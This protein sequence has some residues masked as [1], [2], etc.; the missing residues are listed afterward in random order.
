MIE[1]SANFKIITNNPKVK[2]KYSLVSVEPPGRGVEGVFL[3]VRNEIHLGANLISHPLSGSVKPNESPYKSIVL[4][5]ARG[6]LDTYSLQLIEGAIE[7]LAKLPVRELNF[8]P[9]VMEDFQAIDLD[10]TDSAIFA[11][12]AQYHM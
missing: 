10:L 9:G 4:S 6:A 5:N 12:P 7:V 8:P 1:L 2:E 3:A 11:L